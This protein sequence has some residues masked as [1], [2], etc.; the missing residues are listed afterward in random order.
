MFISKRE[1]FKD[2]KIAQAHRASAIVAFEKF[3]STYIAQEI[4]L[5][6][7]NNLYE[8][9]SITESHD[10]Q[11]FDSADTNCNLHFCYNLAHV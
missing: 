2:N 11:N 5:L 10:T 9:K 7:I 6:L 3:T 1:F 4:M 8:K